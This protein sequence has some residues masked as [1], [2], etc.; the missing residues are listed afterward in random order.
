MLK[1]YILK[2]ININNYNI[3]INKKMKL[4]FTKKHKSLHKK[5]SRSKKI[6][7]GGGGN[8]CSSKS[9]ASKSFTSKIQLNDASEKLIQIQSE[10]FPKIIEE[11][12][13][14]PKTSHWNWYVFPTTQKGNSNTRKTKLPE[15]YKELEFFLN[16]NPNMKN[17][18]KILNLII[19]RIYNP[20][21][22]NKTNL[23]G[24][25]RCMYDIDIG[26]MGISIDFWLSKNFINE[27]QFKDFKSALETLNSLK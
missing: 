23:I 16:N 8:C 19:K 10:V 26:R 17:W 2:N 6:L 22:P 11:L 12:T 20:I 25:K 4:K 24:W 15:D 3:N 21:N 27:P 7:K 9:F 13:K 18:V 14:G 5:Y 1:K